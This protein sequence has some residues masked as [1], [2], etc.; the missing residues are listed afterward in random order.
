MKPVI[1][2]KY[3]KHL[4]QH[5]SQ[6]LI[7]FIEQ[8]FDGNK[9]AFARA[10]GVKP[11]QVSQWLAKNFIVVDGEMY[12]HRRTLK[13]TKAKQFANDVMEGL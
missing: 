3:I 12:S 13:V 6:R 5:S 4:G 9:A 10:Q 2:Q 8:N 7:D 11:Q 1:D